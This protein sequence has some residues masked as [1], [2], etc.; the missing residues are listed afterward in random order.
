MGFL[1]NFTKIYFGDMRAEKIRFILYGALLFQPILVFADIDQKNY[2]LTNTNFLGHPNSIPIDDNRNKT[3]A[4]DTAIAGRLKENKL[5][6]HFYN[7]EIISD[8]IFFK[9]ENIAQQM[10]DQVL[11]L[12]QISQKFW[13]RG[14]LDRAIEL[15]DQA[16]LLILSVNTHTSENLNQQKEDMR[17]M[18]SKRILE[19]YA[20]RKIVINGSQNEIPVI[21]NK[22][23]QSEIDLYTKGGLRN[24]FINSYKRSGKYRQMIVDMLKEEDLPQELSWLPLI[25]S[26]FRVKVLSKSRALGLWQ[27]IPSTGYKFGLNRNRYIDE[28][29]DPEK[30]TQ[31][32]IAYLKELHSHFGDWST[33][34][35]AYNCG[36]SLVLRVIQNQK[37]NYLDN[38]WDLYEQLPQETLRYVPKFLATLHIVKNM[39][40]YGLDK[41]II[42]SALK[43][44]SMTV[45]KKIHLK[46]VA[47]ITG[48]D[49]NSL[50]ELN[51]ELR[52]GIVPGGHYTLKIPEG[53]K[54]RLLANIDQIL[55]LNPAYVEFIKH[56]VQSGESLSLIAR[57]YRTSVANIMLANNLH[58]ANYIVTGKTLKIPNKIK[59]SK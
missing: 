21:I 44:E 43:S 5:Y 2:S 26:G 35:A 51:P 24:H 20:S 40:K 56:R 38:F 54:Q 13:Q 18:I 23:V 37:I 55:R 31:A 49:K 46:N 8:E 22:Q 11:V 4:V 53:N 1:K 58:R 52:Q 16:Y 7:D 27:F 30:S 14:E 19:I 33:A 42:D 12:C 47:K 59:T 50:E 34:L 6:R 32:A 28:R 3:T 9:S 36:E 57:R 25:E 39:E 17:Y 29:L 45:T 10:M 15:L 48:I 41:V